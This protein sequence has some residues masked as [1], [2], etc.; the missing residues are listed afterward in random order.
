VVRLY[1]AYTLKG[2]IYMPM[3]YMNLGSLSS[4]IEQVPNLPE[5][6]IGFIIYQ[7]I[8]TL[9]FFLLFTPPTDSERT[10]TPASYEG[11]P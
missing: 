6:I 7:V 5:T 9:H 10:S 1:G 3:E 2:K 11:H 4:L 8:F